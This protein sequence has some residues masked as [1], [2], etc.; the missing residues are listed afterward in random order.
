M[1]STA[2][3]WSAIT[4]ATRREVPR[5]PFLVGTVPVGSVAQAHLPALRAFAAWLQL[6]PAG[7]TLACRP[8]NATPHW[9][10][11][12]RPCAPRA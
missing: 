11:S 12:T 10:R 4:V 8:T 2:G 5:V 1:L 6:S 7:V 3:P 9:P